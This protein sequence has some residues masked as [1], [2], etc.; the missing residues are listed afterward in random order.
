LQRIETKTAATVSLDGELVDTSRAAVSVFDAAV[1]HGDSYFETLRVAGARPRLL[2][3]HLDRLL[4]ATADAGYRGVPNADRLRLWAN[5]AIAAA[6]LPDAVLRITVSRGQR[7]ALL[8]GPAGD[9]TTIVYV[10]PL[11]DALREI[12]R[13]PAHLALAQCGGYAFPRKS[14]SY[15]RNVELLDAARAAGLDEA[16]IC[17]GDEVIECATANV[18]VATGG[19]LA[20]PPLGRCLPGVTRAALLAAARASGLAAIER[21]LTLRELRAADAVLITNSLIDVRRVAGVD[22]ESVGGGEAHAIHE[23]LLEALLRTYDVD[24]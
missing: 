6:G 18:W 16:L 14:G 23:R 3:A 7:P 11:P 19:E 13:R 12:A 2:G 10:S 5:D 9:A 15:Q 24:E 21:P 8:A 20:T 17:D 4:A 1:L 22:G